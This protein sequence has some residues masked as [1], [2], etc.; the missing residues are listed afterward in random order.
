VTPAVNETTSPA[1]DADSGE[2]GNPVM[3]AP[4]AAA[5]NDAEAVNDPSAESVVAAS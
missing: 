5:N 2:I 3:P 4:E 1:A